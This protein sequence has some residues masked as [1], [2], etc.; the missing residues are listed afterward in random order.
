MTISIFDLFKIGIGPS[1]SHTVG[2]MLAARAFARELSGLGVARIEVTL[3][4]ALSLTGRGH[5]TDRAVILGLAG[6]HPATVPADEAAMIWQ[7]VKSTGELTLQHRESISFSLKHDLLFVDQP[8]P[9]HPNGLRLIAFNAEGTEL[10][11][12]VW[13]SLGGGFITR[14]D[15]QSAE[16]Q[17]VEEVSVPFAFSSAAEL[18]T[19]CEQHHI[20]MAELV[21]ANEQALGH[22]EQAVAEGLDDL[23][24]VMED[25][26][27]RGCQTEG[28]L[29]GGLQVQ[30]RAP[31]LFRRWQA[32]EKQ[33]DPL[34]VMDWV[35]LC[36]MAVNEENA[37]GGR[38]VT[39]PTNGAAGVIPAV[40]A[41]HQQYD[42]HASR[43]SIHTLLLT[44]AAIG[45]LYKRNASISAAEVGCQGEIG[46]ASSMA[47]AG[48]TA[49][50]GGTV[51]QVENA[52]EIA[53]EH[54]LGMTCDPVAGL[55]QVPCIE[56]NTMGAVKAI[57]AARL[58][59]SGDGIHRVSLD[60]VI[61]T[62]YQTGRDMQDR[63]KETSLGGL[64]V[65]V[66]YC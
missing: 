27:Q 61:A 31:V 17:T 13:F 39:A 43:D 42:S 40:V 12:Q 53:M 57:N 7:T 11:N 36:A 3:Y 21:R 51:A 41:F 50:W 4:G 37:A 8:L 44:A 16:S 35:S 10:L 22:S 25:S 59:L 9:E 20:S 33:Q 2:P 6:C 30:R 14:R 24:S 65:N 55:V 45:M 58:A 38:V 63:Y 52:A 48:L 1:S 32:E 49:V 66:I 29:P 23:W 26:I 5:A 62:M 18:Q 28:E 60:Q 56:R 19:L 64:A 47:A 46:V 34:R 54:H 15:Q